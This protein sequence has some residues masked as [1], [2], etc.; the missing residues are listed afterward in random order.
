MHGHCRNSCR[1]CC[2]DVGEHCADW[3]N[4]GEC[5]RNPEFM[6]A[7]CTKSC[8][9]CDARAAAAAAAAEVAAQAAA[10]QLLMQRQQHV[11]AT[12]KEAWEEENLE[13][14]YPDSAVRDVNRAGLKLLAAEEPLVF[15]W[16]Y[17]PWCKQCK[18]V[19]PGVEEA[20]R[21]GPSAGVRWAR[22]DCLAEPEAKAEYDVF[23]YPAFKAVRGTRHRWVET[24]RNR[25]AAVLAALAAR[26]AAGP[27]VVAHTAEELNAAL[28]EQVPP[29]TEKVDAIGG[30]EALAVALLSSPHGAAARAYA[31]L[32]SGCTLRSSPMPFVA[33]H[34]AALL[35]AAGLPPIEPDH[36]AVV[37]LYAEP[38]A[39]P[40]AEQ[41]V[42]RAAVAPLLP[43][44]GEATSE[45]AME[46]ATCRWALGHRVPLLLDFD[47]DPYWGK[48]AGNLGRVVQVHALLFLSP[49]H[50]LLTVLPSYRPTVLPSYCPTFLP[51]PG[52]RA[53]LPLAA[54][55]RSRRRGRARGDGV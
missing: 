47:A 52:P 28:Y 16:F 18:L 32:A 41:R 43:R 36:V 34:D 17:A 25:T 33:V 8:G 4:S 31:N 51:C 12:R 19:R 14:P 53:P 11:S 15:T 3:A 30:G 9:Q 26:E 1:L 49:P 13:A 29:G 5:D 22:L 10:A 27:Y 40:L 23:S 46:E 42:P 45:E 48:R 44:P 6:H 38:P 24:P 7:E 20:A 54:A 50:A 37:K 39:A 35:A 55:C 21:S 2:S